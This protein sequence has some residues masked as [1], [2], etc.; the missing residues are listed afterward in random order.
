MYRFRPAE[1]MTR[2]RRNK[3]RRPNYVRPELMATKPNGLWSW[4]I[5]KLRGNRPYL[6]Y[7]LYMMLDVFSRFVVG[8]MVAE[9]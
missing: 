7:Y 9:N 6:Y 8:W 4:E 2:D 1:K 3:V 5:I